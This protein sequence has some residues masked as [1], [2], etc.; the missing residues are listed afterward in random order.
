MCIDSVTCA[1]I[2]KSFDE[3]IVHVVN[4]GGRFCAIDLN[5]EV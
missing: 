2:C 1:P 3:F 4:N 5:C